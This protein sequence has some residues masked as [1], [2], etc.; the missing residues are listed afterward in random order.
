M[1]FLIAG[2]LLAGAFL[3]WQRWN[4]SAGTRQGGDSIGCDGESG[5]YEGDAGDAGDGG[6]DDGGGD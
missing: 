4:R 2:L 5:D 6:G 3:L 1:K